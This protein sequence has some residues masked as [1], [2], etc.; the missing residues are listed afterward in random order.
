VQAY[1]IIGVIISKIIFLIAILTISL[2]RWK[3]VLKKYFKK[4]ENNEEKK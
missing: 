4:L 2:T 1:G 3:L